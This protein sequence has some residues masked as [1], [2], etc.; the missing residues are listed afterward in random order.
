MEGKDSCPSEQ[1]NTVVLK[2]AFYKTIDYM[3]MEYN[4]TYEEV[5]GTLDMIKMDLYMECRD[6]AT[7]E[8]S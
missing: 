8:D 7:E 5:I 1:P 3:R 2:D 6:L 4:M